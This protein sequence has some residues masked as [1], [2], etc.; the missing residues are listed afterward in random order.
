MSV[1]GRVWM[2][3]GLRRL[4]R[5]L[6]GWRAIGLAVVLCWAVGISSTVVVA[7]QA[8]TANDGVYTAAQAT[9]GQ[10]AFKEKCALCHG[11]NAQ[12]LVGPPLTGPEFIGVWG[13]KSLADLVDKI[14]N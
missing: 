6:G 1:F 9:R 7:G 8:K 3:D 11:D 5:P 4:R 2:Q 12:G 13:G 10:A 14:Q